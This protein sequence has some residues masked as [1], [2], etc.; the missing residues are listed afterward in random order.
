M[1]CT[2]KQLHIGFF[3]WLV[4]RCHY[5]TD[6]MVKN[7]LKLQIKLSI[8][9][10]RN[11]G[12]QIKISIFNFSRGSPPS[13]WQVAKTFASQFWVL[14]SNLLNSTVQKKCRRWRIYLTVSNRLFALFKTAIQDETLELKMQLFFNSLLLQMFPF[15]PERRDS[16]ALVPPIL[17]HSEGT[18]RLPSESLRP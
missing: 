9:G 15:S 10:K 5:Q 17:L 14:G 2:T 13:N 18:C 8:G 3:I 16:I 1:S 12:N 6:I 7:G 11:C 4:A